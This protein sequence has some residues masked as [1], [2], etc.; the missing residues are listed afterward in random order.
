LLAHCWHDTDDRARFCN[1]N[2][3]PMPRKPHQINRDAMETRPLFDPA[4]MAPPPPPPETEPPGE[5]GDRD[6]PVSVSALCRRIDTVLKDTW[7]R[8]IRV[9]GEIGSLTDRT[10]WYFS[11]KD[12]E[13]TLSCVMYA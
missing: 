12:D 5:P 1:P 2:D 7:P 9:R 8:A 6:R 3:D 4:K 11:L 13:A 10:H